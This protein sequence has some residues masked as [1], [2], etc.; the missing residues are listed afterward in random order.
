LL[1][2]FLVYGKRSLEMKSFRVL[3]MSWLESG[4]VW[5][6]ILHYV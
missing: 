4:L 2:K 3:H 5:L 6:F 1:Y